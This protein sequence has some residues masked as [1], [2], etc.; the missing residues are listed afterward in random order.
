MEDIAPV[1]LRMI[2]DWGYAALV[3]VQGLDAVEWSW[4]IRLEVVPMCVGTQR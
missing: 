4:P 3:C 1:V 2:S